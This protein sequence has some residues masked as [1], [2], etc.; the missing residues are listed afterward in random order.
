MPTQ[1]IEL[2]WNPSADPTI[3]GYMLSYGTSLNNLN[4]EIDA[5][6]NTVIEV[7]GLVTGQTN[8]FTIAAYN[9]QGVFGA[10]SA[11]IAYPASSVTISQTGGLEVTLNVDGAQWAVDGG[12]WETN[13][14]IVSGLSFGSHTITFSSMGGWTAPAA[15]TI[16]VSS[17]Q[18]NAITATYVSGPE[19][20]GLT[21][22]L[23]VSAAQW[24]VDGGAWQ[25]SGAIVSG[26]SAG[27]HTLSFSTVSGW[28]AP[29]SETIT[30]ASDATNSITAN[31]VAVP[32]TGSLQVTLNVTGAQWSVDNG[33]WQNSGAIVSGLSVGSHTVTFSTASGWTTPASQTVTIVANQTDSISATYFVVPQT[34]GLKVTL[35]A[36]GAQWSVDQGTLQASGATVSG[37]S[38]GSHIV[39]FSAVSGWTTPASQTVTIV[40]SQTN[41]ISATYIAVSQTGGLKVTLNATGAQ[42]SVD[43]GTMQVSGATVSGLTADSHTVSFS[44]VSGYTTPASQTVSIVANQTNSISATYVVSQSGSLRVTLNVAGAQWSVDNGAWQKSGASVSG[45]SVSTHTVTFSA[46]SGYTT[47]ASQTV[48]ITANRTKSDTAT[49]IAAPS[50]GNLIVTLN[51]AGAQWSVDSGAWQNSGATLSGL[52]V[53][54]HTITFS[55]V[56]GWT[57]PA[58]QT[59][60]I[61]ASQTASVTASYIAVPQTGSLQ[62]T[63]N[64]AGAQWSVDNG[65]W[66]NSGAIVS[67][68]SVG[69]HTINFS[70]MPGW[71]T[72]ASKTVSIVASQTD[73]VT[74]TYVAIP[75]TGALEVTLSPAVAQWSVDS[76]VWQNSA[77][78]VAGLSV[79]SHTVTFSPMSG[80]TTPTAQTVS[81]VAN[82][83]NSIAATYVVIPQTGALQVT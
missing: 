75:Q 41:S 83:T 23:N 33:A 82:Q 24:A 36:T 13:G 20:G 3:A 47:P 19:T 18:T 5:G 42:W 9:A 72:P 57:T 51:V 76:G 39:S 56:A 27:S 8:Y 12:A 34:G 71:T 10:A 7:T 22:T 2:G 77:A 6:T 59:V 29:A 74:A 11:P 31:Y 68:L 15:E 80:W 67:G 25:N 60:S 17:G 70:T 21:V 35:N 38:A 58:S 45:L 52:S 30:V 62:V 61:V 53:G 16:S 28:T 1:S 79:G 63:L 65:A 32:Q 14:A 81:V 50:T 64:V 78:V 4:N 69:S 40:A 44:A 49:Y 73:A 43:Q 46:V 54:S 37:L 48:T 26:L 66:Q 55:A